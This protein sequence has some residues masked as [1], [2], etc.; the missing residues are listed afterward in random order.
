MDTSGAWNP[1]AGAVYQVGAVMRWT[2][3]ATLAAPLVLAAAPAVR[4]Q[5]TLEVQQSTTWTT[6][7]T[8]PEGAMFFGE[9]R[10]QHR[11]VVKGERDA[12]SRP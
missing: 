4:A 6:E 10:D 9:E 8:I 1:A 5:V 7:L 11:L 3:L 12:T 2:R